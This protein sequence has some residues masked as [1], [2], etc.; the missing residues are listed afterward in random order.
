MKPTND[1]ARWRLIVALYLREMVD[2][3]MGIV[4][5]LINEV[6]IEDKGRNDNECG[7]CPHYFY[8]D[9]GGCREIPGNDCFERSSVYVDNGE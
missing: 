9:Q 8:P 3:G 5:Y 1:K 4:D 7:G 2:K 6:L